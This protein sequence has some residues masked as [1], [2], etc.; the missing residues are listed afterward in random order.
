MAAG[1]PPLF[2]SPEDLQA[3][4]DEYFELL[5]VDIKDKDLHTH[6][7]STPTITGLVLFLGFCDRHSFYDYEKKKE[8]THTIKKARLRV[9]NWYEKS[10]LAGQAS[11]TI[12][13]LKNL[14]WKD[15][16]E[17]DINATVSQKKFDDFYT[18]DKSD[19]ADS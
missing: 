5:H 1:R 2:K 4:I 16:T 15:K 7:D 11:G 18:E 19:E 6:S 14:G 13:A 10:L 3:K 9:E 12:F 17:Q 8:F